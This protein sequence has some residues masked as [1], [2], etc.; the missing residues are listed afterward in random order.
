M[1]QTGGGGVRESGREVE[2]HQ[3]EEP[4]FL[5]WALLGRE[6]KLGMEGQPCHLE[7][8]FSEW[9]A[10]PWP[11]NYP[12]EQDPNSGCHPHLLN[13]RPGSRAQH[14][15]AILLHTEVREPHSARSRGAAVVNWDRKTLL[16]MS[17]SNHF[18]EEIYFLWHMNVS[19]KIAHD[20]SP[21]NTVGPLFL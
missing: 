7:Q 16:P 13:Q 5:H 11:Q 10:H 15:L 9:S 1:T 20:C 3:V 19:H 12:G 18:S 6:V 4:P 2:G 17:L 14:L 21:T 8:W